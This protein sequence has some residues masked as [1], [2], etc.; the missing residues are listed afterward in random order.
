MPPAG[1]HDQLNVTGTVVDLADATLNLSPFNSYSPAVNDSFVIVNNDGADSI[2]GVFKMGIGGTDVNGGLLQEGDTI[3]EFLGSPLN[4]TITYQGGD[5]GN[6]VVLTVVAPSSGN[7]S[8]TAT[9]DTYDATRN[10]PLHID[11]PGVLTNDSDPDS[12]QT[13][14][15]IIVTPPANASSFTLNS[16]GSFDYTPVNGY[17][18]SDSFTYKA[19]DDSGDTGTQDS[20]TVTVTINVQCQTTFTVT[21]TTDVDNPGN[22]NHDAVP[23]DGFCDNGN[24]VCTLRAAIEEANQ[25]NAACGPVTINFKV[26]GTITLTALLP[27]LQHDVIINGPGAGILR[28]SGNNVQTQI[29][30]IDSTFTVQINGLSMQ[31]ANGNNQGG[32]IQNN[33]NLTLTD[34]NVSNNHAAKAGGIQNNAGA[35]LTISGCTISHNVS[36]T[37]GGGIQNTGSLTLINSVLAGNT[38]NKRGGG[39]LNDTADS[40]GPLGTATIVNSAIVGNIADADNNNGTSTCLGQPC[41]G[42]GIYNGGSYTLLINTIVAGNSLGSGAADDI[43]GNNVDT[44]NS[45]HNLIGTGGSGGLSNG[46][47]GNQVGVVNPR[48]DQNGVPQPGSPAIDQGDDC[49]LTGSCTGAGSITVTSDLNGQTRPLGEHVEVGAYEVE[50]FVVNNTG[51]A[52]DDCTPLDVGN[53]CSLREAINAANQTYG[54]YIAFGIPANTDPGCDLNGV[55]TIKPS[56]NLLPIV[57]KVFIDGYS[58]TGASPNTLTLIGDADNVA[59]DNAVLKIVVD[60]GSLPNDGPGLDL[61][62]ESDFSTIKGLV[63][64]HWN[65]AGI[66]INDSSGNV[67]AGNFIGTDVTGALPAGAA[68]SSG[69]LIT[70]DCSAASFLNLIGGEDRASRNL[71]SGNGISGVG[72]GTFE[73]DCVFGNQVEGN[74]IGTDHTGKLAIPNNQ[75]VTI[76]NDSEGNVIGCEQIEGDNLISG[77]TDAGVMVRDTLGFTPNF[78][79]G[80]FIGTDRTGKAARPNNRGVV[81][82]NAAGNVIGFPPYGNV[83]SGNITNGIEIT[84]ESC[85]DNYVL[86]NLIG[87]DLTG[88]A[89][90]GNQGSGILISNSS[91]NTIGDGFPGDGNLISANNDEGIALLGSSYNLIQGNFIGTDITGNVVPQL[92]N[93]SHGIEVYMTGPVYS[94]DNIIGGPN[95]CDCVEERAQKPGSVQKDKAAVQSTMARKSGLAKAG[96]RKPFADMLAAA[97]RNASTTERVASLAMRQQAA[98]PSA[99]IESPSASQRTTPNRSAAVTLL[100]SGPPA[101]PNTSTSNTI[102]GNAGDGVRVS[103]SGDVNNLISMNLI[104]ANTGLGIDLAG[105]GVTPNDTSLTD[106]N[107]TDDGANH[108]QNFP[109]ITGYDA[110][111][112]TV[113]GI[114]D[115]GG[116][117]AS[118]PNGVEDFTIEIFRNPSGCDLSG[119]GEGQE[120][121]GSGTATLVSPGHYTFSVIVTGTVQAGQTYTATATDFNGNTSEFSP[122]SCLGKPTTPTATND[123]PACENGSVQLH[124]LDAGAGATYLWTGPAGFSDTAREPVVTNLSPAKAGEYSVV[125]TIDGGCPSDP[126]KTTLVVKPAPAAPTPGNNG[127]YLEGQTIHLTASNVPGTYSWTGPNGFTSSEQNPDIPNATIAKAGDY[128]VFVTADGCPSLTQTTNVVVNACPTDLEVNDGGDTHDQVPGNGVCLDSNNKCTLRAA[129]EEANE[130][131]TCGPVNITFQTDFNIALNSG[132]GELIVKH[133]VNINPD[134]GTTLISRRVT[135]DGNSATRLFTINNGRTVSIFNLTLTGGNGS[136]GDGGAV[137]N[138]GTLTLNGVTL[139]NPDAT[140]RA[141][142]NSAINGGAIRND[143]ALILTNATISGNNATGDGGGLYNALGTATLTNVTIAYNRANNDNTGGG[144]GGGLNV[145]GGTVLLHNTIVSDNYQGPS[146]STTAD[147]IAGLVDGASTYN[148]I[149]AGGSGGLLNGSGNNQVGGATAFLGAL[150]DNGGKTPTL[151]LL[152]NSPAL[153]A[154]DDAVVNSPLFITKDQRGLTRPKDSDLTAGAHV[155]IGAY[156][157]QPTETR[158]T[159][160]GANVS[161]DINDVRLTFPCVPSGSC[162]GAKTRRD[163]EVRTEGVQETVDLTLIPVPIDAPSGSGPAFDITPNYSFYDTPVQICFYLPA[164]TNPTT[165]GNIK[166]YHRESGTF[167][168]HAETRDFASKTVCINDITSFSQFVVNQPVAPTAQ[169]GEVSGQIVDTDGKPVEGAAIRMSGTENRLTITDAQGNYHFDN[170][171]TNG[172]YIVTPSRA[173]FSFSPAQRSFSQLAAHTD[174]VF[175]ATRE[176][177]SVSPL[178]TTEYFVRQHYLDFLG[179]EPDESGFNFWVNNIESCGTDLACRE[180]KRI[181]TSAA[182]FLSI[183]FQHTGFLVYRAYEA[184]YGDLDSAPAPMSLREFTPDT[185]K[186]SNGLV[187]NQNGW[188]QKLETNKQTFMNDFV[189]R[190]RFT[191]AYPTSMTPAEFVDKLFATGHVPSTDADYAASVALF[192]TATDTSNMLTRAL[193]LRRLAENSSLTRRQFNRAFVLM[194]YFGYLKRDPNTGRDADFSGYSFWLDKLNSFNGNFE[195]A[196]MVKAFISSPEYRGRFPR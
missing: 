194:E 57:S 27:S 2:T 54:A 60:G 156:E 28:V 12:G 184:A 165:F 195:N 191:T 153:D 64:S 42:G 39:L 150:I 141:H 166:I 103:S 131:T 155:D 187:V 130:L 142:T 134:N 16:D 132:L 46:A 18:G 183:E 55:C 71:I 11:A 192:G 80:N 56:Q 180:V 88:K 115:S 86:G 97:N 7:S 81:F 104:F 109:R 99:N 189:Q 26:S 43:L 108:L 120:Y 31:L 13:L 107:D 77:N 114:L 3:K 111:T 14:T 118:E 122:C 186:I 126:G 10:T 52:D 123:G 30:K 164:I 41:Q 58:Q 169:N 65:V 144:T 53:G 196:E 74:Y 185:Q 145:A 173:N 61:E 143:G 149:G 152:Y 47:N 79:Q 154:G 9:A 162:V 92:G 44:A 181:D 113:S 8:P 37:G 101:I 147:N 29:F 168:E 106:P 175:T 38:A 190:P 129:I 20:N 15:A 102:A 161:V 85:A 163:N 84:G 40:S 83:I 95:L 160:D 69:V 117:P 193:V 119:N 148:L 33:G 91:Y 98:T 72:I 135:L 68:E 158:G 63:L 110:N 75:G 96:A 172:F 73:G 21:S 188:Q 112:S 167:V 176:G 17:I 146:P 45:S 124:T 19:R 89:A 157:R 32:G 87:T 35:T 121:V 178:D 182:F 174:A 140:N 125:V 25:T 171:E 133:N 23:G 159:P 76:E 105:D 62:E 78:V 138:N 170:V 36:T 67:I 177:T 128:N 49:V 24:G 116:P 127:P 1:N 90:L 93:G 4:A 70:S 50:Q 34:C 59:G 48:V 51:D 100:D 94:T 137:Q 22:S 179:R 5:Q 6:D 139:G 82:D 136:G 151:G 66:Y